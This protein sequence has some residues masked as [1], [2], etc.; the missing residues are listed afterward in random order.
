MNCT[1]FKTFATIGVA[2]AAM[3]AP[4]AA[5]TIRE[6]QPFRVYQ[7][8]SED[9]A[10]I[11]FRIESVPATI[12]KIEVSLVDS[13]GKSFFARHLANPSGDVSGAIDE[14]PVGGPYRF[15]VE[16]STA[17]GLLLTQTS[18]DLLVGDLWILAGQ[19]NMEG[20]AHLQDL[21]PPSDMVHV[22]RLYDEWTIAKDP[23]SDP[24]LAVDP[25][26]WR[27]TIS[28]IPDSENL[29]F[30]ARS[31]GF[32][33]TDLVV[34]KR[35]VAEPVRKALSNAGVE[36]HDFLEAM[37]PDKGAALESEFRRNRGAGLGVAFGKHLQEETGVPIGLIMN[38]NGGTNM[39]QWD[40]NLASYGGE[41]LYGSLLR[42]VDLL[43]GEVTGIVWYQGESDAE[44]QEQIDNYS[45]RTTNFVQQLRRDFNARDL[46]FVLVQLGRVYD[47]RRNSSYWMSIQTQQLELEQS[48]GNAWL[49]AATGESMS[50]HI[51]LDGKGQR[52]LGRKLA[53][54]VLGGVYGYDIERGPRL[55]SA[56]RT[57]A[58]TIRLEFDSVNGS[59]VS[60][61]PFPGFVVRDSHRSYQTI[62]DISIDPNDGN[63]VILTMLY[64]IGDGATVTFGE[65][66]NPVIGLADELD[67]TV[68]VFGP[69]TIET[70]QTR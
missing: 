13:E 35:P 45:E 17:D 44:S 61:A 39:S 59:L 52:E 69:I 37:R 22:F 42:R 19:S 56:V 11:P 68:P 20:T 21:E 18:T 8:S 30:I 40:P 48:L 50:D 55:K 23:L 47:K 12:K 31:N 27:S 33:S 32:S 57:D 54:I 65:G 5:Q 43:G 1:S 9:T 34:R 41:S 10:R 36:W 16:Y 62:E 15:A 25:V 46:P 64:P 51:H 28:Q 26:H 70:E 24:N 58:K 4:A 3:V 53:D 67:L 29:D 60:T 38:A 14:V 6:P 49:A 2:A 66:I 7:R 63:A